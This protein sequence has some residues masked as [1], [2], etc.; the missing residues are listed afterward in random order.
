MPELSDKI[1]AILESEKQSEEKYFS[2]DASEETYYE[3]IN[4][5]KQYKQKGLKQEDAKEI[6][7]A[8]LKS[9]EVQ[10]NSVKEDIL[11]SIYYIVSGFCSPKNDIW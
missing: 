5:L 7:S 6:I 9:A 3:I 1:I 2:L 11:M 4:V 8:I 10:Q